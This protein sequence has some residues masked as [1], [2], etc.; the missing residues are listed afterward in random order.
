MDYNDI[1]LSLL[2]AAAMASLAG[3][4]LIKTDKKEEKFKV[5]L[6]TADMDVM[7][8]TAIVT[9]IAIMVACHPEWVS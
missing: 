9:F 1:V 2:A 7:A 8:L 5:T 4:G 3:L 6:A